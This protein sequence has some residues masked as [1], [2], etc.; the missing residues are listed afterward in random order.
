MTVDLANVVS[1][2]A[3]D[4]GGIGDLGMTDQAAD[5]SR[6]KALPH[7]VQTPGLLDARR[8]APVEIERDVVGDDRFSEGLRVG[9]RIELA[10]QGPWPDIEPSCR[11]IVAMGVRSRAFLTDEC[12]PCGV[13]PARCSG[14]CGARHQ[15]TAVRDRPVDADRSTTVGDDSVLSLHGSGFRC[16]P[17]GP[18]TSSR[19]PGPHQ[20]SRTAPQHS[21]KWWWCT[22]SPRTGLQV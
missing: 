14:P 16:A 18:P 1:R 20:P 21:A 17:D 5:K 22:H 4:G 8:K 6:N 3:S 12:G 15:P 11:K 13:L 7:R 10:K 19:G 9:A 2:D